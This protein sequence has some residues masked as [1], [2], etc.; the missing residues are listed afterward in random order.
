M[1]IR[2]REGGGGR[3]AGASEL[4]EESESV[5][6]RNLGKIAEHGVTK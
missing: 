2:E 1:P 4:G 6:D 5:K 3:G